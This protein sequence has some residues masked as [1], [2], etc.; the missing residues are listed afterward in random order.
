MIK[1]KLL[2]FL[3]TAVL[4]F[5]LVSCTIPQGTQQ[6]QT[7]GQKQEQVNSTSTLSQ[8]SANEPAQLS[9]TAKSADLPDKNSSKKLTVTF[10]DVG[11]GDSIFIQAPSGKTMLIDA[12]VPEMGSKVV[13]YIKSRGIN[14][15]DIF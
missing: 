7:A 14:K 13:N 1:R 4:I 10:V 5:S 2:V 15:I 6:P 11:Q 9:G 12:G 8:Q 3:L